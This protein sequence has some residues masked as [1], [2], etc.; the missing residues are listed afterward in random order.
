MARTKLAGKHYGYAAKVLNPSPK[1]TLQTAK[2]FLRK[3]LADG[4]KPTKEVKAAAKTE[5]INPN[6][7]D[8]ARLELGVKTEHDGPTW[9]WRLPSEEEKEKPAEVVL[10]GVVEQGEDS[11]SLTRDEKASYGIKDNE[12]H[13]WIRDP[14]YW[15][16]Q[17]GVSGD[18]ARILKHQVPGARIIM[19][20]GEYVEN[21]SDLIL[22]AVPKAWV[23]KNQAEQR[24][25]EKEY[26]GQIDKQKM[27][28]DFDADDLD[29]LARQ[30]AMNSFNAHAAG[31]IG[32]ASPS[33]GMPMED[34]IKNRG[35]T[36]KEIEREELS[37]AL[38]RG[39]DVES[40]VQQLSEKP[41]GSG[42]KFISI[43]ANVRPRNLAQPAAK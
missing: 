23:E 27:A 26:H 7:L 9:I 34:Y 38:K 25:R 33:H 37:Y 43:P 32:T 11:F 40:F 6:Y 39:T 15:T 8:K 28:D 35:L 18:D 31:L 21:G 13:C 22:A 14:R 10:E 20:D 5:G 2:D 4:F 41:R 42:G 29:T 12:Q 16:K 24:Q 30:K 17:P 19:K 3:Q 1:S 36:A